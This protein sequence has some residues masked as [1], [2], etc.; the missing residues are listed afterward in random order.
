MLTQE[1]LKELLDYDPE[2]GVFTW[3]SIVFGSHMKVGS[4]A[5]SMYSNGYLRIKINGKD[6]RAHRLAWLYM[7]GCWPTN[8]IDHINRVRD[9]NRIA[10]L[11]EATN[12]ENQWN[13]GK[14]KSSTSGFTGVSWHKKSGK[15]QSR[16]AVNKKVIQLGVFNTPEEAHAAYVR[17]KAEHHKF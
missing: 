7:Y 15:W 8:Q 17:A 16:I 12:K 2:T 4:V 9:D 11:R 14:Q 5:G 10:N 13:R 6:Y 3:K 1:R